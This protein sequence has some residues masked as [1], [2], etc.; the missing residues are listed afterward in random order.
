MVFLSNFAQ[1]WNPKDLSCA[2]TLEGHD[3]VLLSWILSSFL[4]LHK[5]LPPT[6]SCF[7]TNLGC[8]V[9]S[10]ELALPFVRL[11]GW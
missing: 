7:L 3:Q 1:I 10:F 9:A 4:F 6:P 11:S 5:N 8:G 2:A